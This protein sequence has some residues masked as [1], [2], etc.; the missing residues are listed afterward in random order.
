MSRRTRLVASSVV[1]AFT[2]FAGVAVARAQKPYKVEQRWVIGGDGSWDY[3]LADASTHRLYIAHLT[4]VDV[5]DTDS[6]KLVG[7]VSGLTHVHGIV[8]LPDGK[9][10]FISDGGANT[11]VVFDPAT[12]AVKT[13]I[14]AGTN[15][16]GMAYEASTNTLWAF[17]G[18]SKNA[19]VIDAGTLAA[20]GTV[21]LPGKPEFP[22]SDDAGT[23]YVNIEDKNAIV[24]LDVKA[25]KATA[26]WPLAGCES[27]SGLA[28]DK[29]GGRLFSVCDGKKMAVTDAKTGKS[30]ATPT[31][32]D[33]PDAAGYDAGSKL[34]FASNEDG[35]LSVVD[36]GKAGY[37]VVQ[38]LRTMSGARTMALD[39]A[40]GKIYTVSAKLGAKPAPSAANPHGRPTPV[41]GS[42]TVLVIGRE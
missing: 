25:Q 19:T 37:P 40:S 5:V 20:V 18:A 41:P 1:L 39:S 4:K 7:A 32:G 13:K 33:G 36:A 10:G 34:A 24:R 42:F 2:V 8:L 38:T 22:Q 35:T 6:G 29:D 28:F 11:V 14:A 9:T 15:P 17:N 16:D 30:L 31:I 27:P 23:I 21:A 26:T 3:L 12:L